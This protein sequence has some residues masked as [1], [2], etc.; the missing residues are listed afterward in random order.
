MTH[1]SKST[2]AESSHNRV[3]FL[4]R[5]TRFSN[6]RAAG[7]ELALQLQMYRARDPTST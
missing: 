5:T 1:S 7:R 4:K 3:E 6:L 2:A